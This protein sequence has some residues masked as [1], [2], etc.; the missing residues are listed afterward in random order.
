MIELDT[1]YVFHIPTY[2]FEN[3]ELFLLNID[4]LI[5]DLIK[6]FEEKG[7]ESLYMTKVTGYYNSRS[8]DEIL[9]T[10]FISQEDTEKN[11]RTSP[12]KIFMKWYKENNDLLQQ[13]AFAYEKNNTMYVEKII[14]KN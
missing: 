6:Q 9:L 8:F 2:K 14:K 7:Y 12:D 1:K 13:E 11:N 3:N 10:L 5:K 4:K